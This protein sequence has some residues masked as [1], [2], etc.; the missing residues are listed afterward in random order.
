MGYTSF[1]VGNKRGKETL[2]QQVSKPPEQSELQHDISQSLPD[3][4]RR[5]SRAGIYILLVLIVLLIVSSAS[6]LLVSL[7]QGL[8]Q[9]VVSTATLVPTQQPSKTQTVAP[10]ATTNQ[11]VISTSTPPI[12]TPGNT[13]VPPLQLP[14][15]RYLV[16]E[17]Q[18]KVY[19]IS[20]T[21]G[22]PQ[23]ITTPGYL[24]N[25]AVRPILTFS[26]QLLYS[27]NGL[28]LIVIFG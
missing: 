6:L 7:A 24:Y 8:S 27:G 19:W 12:F 21:G 28:W 18:D 3:Q 10:T 5:F 15:G 9:T 1:C 25:Q 4:H 20:G 23:V 2:T 16:Y 26:G 14:S 17:Q 11:N 13:I 22:L